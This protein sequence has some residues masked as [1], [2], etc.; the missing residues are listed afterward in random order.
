MDV[1][2]DEKRLRRMAREAG[3]QDVFLDGLG[4]RRRTSVEALRELMAALHI[5]DR[6]KPGGAQVTV[7]RAGKR[8]VRVAREEGW[9]VPAKMELV[10]ED[11]ERV[12]VER[13]QVREEGGRWRI[14]LGRVL[15]L[16]VHRLEMDAGKARRCVH[17]LASP[18]ALR[19]GADYPRLSVFVP[20]YA[21]HS[22]RSLGIGDFSDLG[23]LVR[24][25]G[26]SAGGAEGCKPVP[27]GDAAVLE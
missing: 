19:M 26:E 2:I 4:V 1:T 16:G 14:G 7:A 3:L 8:E 13:K 9:A 5:E 25:A 23:E 18:G 12:V 21:V 15:P 10:L 22:R 20:L 24:W 17:V 11:G 6:R 27:A